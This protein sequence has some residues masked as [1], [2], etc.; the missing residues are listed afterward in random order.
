MSSFEPAPSTLTLDFAGELSALHPGDELTFGRGAAND[1]PIDSNPLLHRR[2]GHISFRHGQWW[3]RNAGSRIAITVT[4]LDS[5]SNVML[6]SGRESALTFPRARIT[7]SAGSSNY[8]LLV[9]LTS[10]DDASR[11]DFD[12]Q[13][14]DATSMTMDQSQLP[15]VGDQRLLAIALAE[16]KIRAPHEPLVLPSNKSIANRFGWSMTTFNRKLDRLCKK[17][18]RAGVSGLVGRPGELATNRRQVLAEHLVTTGVLSAADLELLEAETHRT[19]S[20][21]ARLS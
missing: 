5:P 15:L 8:E 9:D 17:L 13:D 6:T 11:D 18:A 7:F 4:D 2:F 21:K 14:F 10:D 3:I 12:D 20:A 16:S 19:A 1:I